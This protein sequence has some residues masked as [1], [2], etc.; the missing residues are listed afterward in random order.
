MRRMTVDQYKQSCKGKLIIVIANDVQ[1]ASVMNILDAVIVHSTPKCVKL[2]SVQSECNVM[3]LN[4]ELRS[5][6]HC[7]GEAII[8]KYSEFMSV[9]LGIQLAKHMQRIVLPSVACPAQPYFSTLSHKR[10]DFH[11]KKK[12]LNT[13][14][15]F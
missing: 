2:Y 1:C 8:T 12:L 9:T 3:I 7:G 14:C 6:T 4:V 11:N 5:R 15:V 13:K 10:H